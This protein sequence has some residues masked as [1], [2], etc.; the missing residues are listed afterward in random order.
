MQFLD[1]DCLS[2]ICQYLS[3]ANIKN[4]KFALPNLI[5]IPQNKNFMV[6][7]FISLSSLLK[8]I[9]ET[10]Q[11]KYLLYNR[12]IEKN[13]LICDI[14]HL[15]IR[16][17]RWTILGDYSS[18]VKA[19]LIQNNV[20]IRINNGY[21]LAVVQWRYLLRSHDDYNLYRSYIEYYIAENRIEE[22]IDFWGP[23]ILN[24][25]NYVKDA[26]YFK[27]L[28]E[29]DPK[30]IYLIWSRL[31]KEKQELLKEKIKSFLLDNQDLETN[32]AS[33]LKYILENWDQLIS[34]N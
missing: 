26:L 12:R 3:F 9:F 10:G 11:D 33:H 8:S 30:Y 19:N 6:A 5:L 7:P 29:R 18:F 4:L 32:K 27:R 20:L 21:S 17:S 16:R 2:V 15:E 25:W 34:L 23:R 22:R 28:L 14:D 13:L 31:S 1:K 24:I